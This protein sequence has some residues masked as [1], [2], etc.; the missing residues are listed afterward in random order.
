MIVTVRSKKRTVLPS[1][2]VGDQF[3]V[4]E[5]PDGNILLKST[6]PRPCKVRLEKHRGYTVG[7]LDRPINQQA[8]KAALAEFP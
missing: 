1:A 2:N 5:F 6:A 7:V 8:L 3:E 4:V